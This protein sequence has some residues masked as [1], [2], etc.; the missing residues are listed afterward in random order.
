MKFQYVSASLAASQAGPV[1]LIAKTDREIMNVIHFTARA[2][3]VARISKFSS[4][5]APRQ[6]ILEPYK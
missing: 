6:G 1:E 4:T 5:S 3:K 2:V